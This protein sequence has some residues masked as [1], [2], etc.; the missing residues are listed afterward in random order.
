LLAAWG[1]LFGH[2]RVLAWFMWDMSVRQA[3]ILFAVIGFVIM[4]PCAGPINAAIMLCG[5]VTGLAY[6]AARS[7][8]LRARP[9]K[10]VSS[11]RIGRLEI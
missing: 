3:A 11:E 5:G 9:S 4:L 7:R 2:E 8:F 10:A 6:L 1:R